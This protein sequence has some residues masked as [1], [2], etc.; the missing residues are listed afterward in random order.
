[1]KNSE[2]IVTNKNLN[3]FDGDLLVFFASKKY[4]TKKKEPICDDLVKSRVANA[5]K[6]GDFE[7]K[8]DQI[9]LYY[10]EYDNKNE[11]VSAKRVLILGLGHIQKDNDN[12]LNR[13]LFRKAGGNIAKVCTKLKAKNIMINFP[14]IDCLN[15]K[16]IGEC[17]SEGLLL[18]DYRFLKYKTKEK[19][20]DQYK[21]LSQV[22]FFAKE[23]I[24]QIRKGVK[25]GFNSS[26]ATHIIFH[27]FHAC[28][29][30]YTNTAGIK[31]DCF[32]N[33]KYSF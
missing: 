1:M 32:A 15:F 5:Y 9:F 23:K 29:L 6:L 12:D 22:R 14:I 7:A 31:C 27:I 8:E 4:K 11:K 24:N 10:P 30:L 28:S 16:E 26:S 19:E 25:L 21:G 20:K 2:L 3:K 18:G 33:K 17:L 13:E